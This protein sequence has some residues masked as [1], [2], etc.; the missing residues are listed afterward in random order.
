MEHSSISHTFKC[1]QEL[2]SLCQRYVQKE[3]RE[4]VQ[5]RKENGKGNSTEKRLVD[6]KTYTYF[7]QFSPVVTK[8]Q[9]S[10]AAPK[11]SLQNP[12]SPIKNTHKESP[13]PPPPAPPPQKPAPQ[14][15]PP[16]KEVTQPVTL[17]LAPQL[18]TQTLSPLLP[19]PFTPSSL[20]PFFTVKEKLTKLAS[21]LPVKDD[22]LDDSLAVTQSNRWKE[23]YPKFVIIS[24]F[25]AASDEQ[26][27]LSSVTSAIAKHLVPCQLLS[28]THEL[29]KELYILSQV[30]HLQNL[31]VA[32]NS[33]NIAKANDF[34]ALLPLQIDKEATQDPHFLK[35]RGYLFDTRVLELQ[36]TSDLQ[37]KPEEK[38][39]LW[40]MCTKLCTKAS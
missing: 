40:Q 5:E 2:I 37:I 9:S 8:E 1:Y 18:H 16:I 17:V 27:F 29:A 4:E 36:V 11:Q 10:K 30:K 33:Q 3:L 20:P 38:R 39:A 12:V 25:D 7:Q 31:L 23:G 24:F 32:V 13:L 15:A 26:L 6:Q 22:I 14:K 21:A 19:R 35:S 34:L 28:A